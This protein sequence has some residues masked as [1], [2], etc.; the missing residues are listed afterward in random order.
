T[1]PFSYRWSLDGPASGG[2]AASLNVNTAALTIGDH[3]VQVIVSGQCASVTNSATLTVNAGTT[4]TALSDATVC[5]GSDAGFSTVASGTG[6][7]TY[8]WSLDGSVTGSNAANLS[9]NTAAVTIGEHAVQVIVSGQCGSVTNSATLTIN[10][11]VT[12]TSPDDATVCQG[13]NATFS[14]VASGTGPFTYQW[15]LD[16]S[17][18]G[19]NGASLSVNSS[20]LTIGDHTVRLI[21]SGQCGSVTNTAMLKVNAGITA[22]GPTDATVCQGADAGFSTVASGTGPFTYQWSLDGESLQAAG[23]SL[24]MS[25][26]DLFTGDHVVQV[27]LTGECGSISHAATLTVQPIT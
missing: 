9:V 19:S 14:T 15:S 25:T 22:T 1:G 21:V 10:A 20:A 17:V 27:T 26:I 8:Q 16:G 24:R 23:P 2:N 12:A 3:A 7:F 18:T 4:A 11:G 6:P 5:Q 13:S